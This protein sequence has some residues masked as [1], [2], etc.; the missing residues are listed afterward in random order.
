MKYVSKDTIL[1]GIINLVGV[2]WG[3]DTNYN[4]LFIKKDSNYFNMI[5]RKISLKK[6]F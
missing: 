6:L 1:W 3:F 4:F 5:H 2:F